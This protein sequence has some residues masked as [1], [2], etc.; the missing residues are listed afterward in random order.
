MS[1]RQ[2]LTADI[3]KLED[4]VRHQ[5]AFKSDEVENF[6]RS[7]TAIDLLHRVSDPA[8]ARAAD[9]AD[10]TMKQKVL[11]HY[12]PMALD[13]V[14]EALKDAC[15]LIEK[16]ARD[17]WSMTFYTQAQFE[18]YWSDEDASGHTQWVRLSTIAGVRPKLEEDIDGVCWQC[19]RR[20]AL[21]HEI[22]DGP[23]SQRFVRCAQHAT[24]FIEIPSTG[25]DV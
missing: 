2:Y 5:L 10:A 14:N 20:F 18:D 8:G 24:G 19:E 22:E 12:A 13:A 15:K 1:L 16:T 23:V 4:E 25:D 9:A 6:I 21:S 3:L 17:Y 11:A 7:R